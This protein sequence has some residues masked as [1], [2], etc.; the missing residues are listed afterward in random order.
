MN[1]VIRNML[2]QAGTIR[3]LCNCTN[4]LKKDTE[5][6]AIFRKNICTQQVGPNI[7]ICLPVFDCDEVGNV[8]IITAEDPSWEGHGHEF[9]VTKKQFRKFMAGPLSYLESIN[10]HIR[11]YLWDSAHYEKHCVNDDEYDDDNDDDYITLGGC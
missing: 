11:R 5:R 8:I 10:Q 9:L 2:T 1:K 3:H 4:M 7:R 6:D